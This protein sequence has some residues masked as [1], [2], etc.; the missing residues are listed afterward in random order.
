MAGGLALLDKPAAASSHGALYAL[1]RTFRTRRVGHAG[2]LDPFATGLLCA[3][4]G[5]AT[6]LAVLLS[7]LDKTYTA[8]FRFGQASDTLDTEGDVVATGPVPDE[9]HLI[10]VLPR[11]VGPQAQRPPD[12]SAVQVGG[13]RAYRVAR[14]GGDVELPE[15]QVDVLSLQ[16]VGY[17]SPDLQLE[18]RCSAGTYVRALARDIGAALGTVAH[19]VAL[20]RTAVGPFSVTEA[21][22][23]DDLGESQLIAPGRFV[24]RLDAVDSCV[25]T[26][27]H[28]GDVRQGK[29]P[30]PGYFQSLVGSG[31]Y[32]AALDEGGELVALLMRGAGQKGRAQQGQASHLR[33]AAVFAAPTAEGARRG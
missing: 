23:P 5:Q 9:Q 24:A 16:A 10:D 15:R 8:T 31:A 4:V 19:V 7:G 29:P 2:T 30:R 22:P 32:V 12:Y 21:A 25:V 26:P 20:R 3:L 18:M 17:D 6:R 27:K 33:Y 1:K 13:K 28:L 14:S 11:F